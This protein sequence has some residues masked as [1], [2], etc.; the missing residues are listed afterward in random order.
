MRPRVPAG[1][2]GPSGP[3]GRSFTGRALILAVVVITL[4]VSLAVP[5]RAWFA[6]RAE[7][8][9]LRADVE[10]ARE[11]VEALQ[12]Q[13]ERWTDPAFVAAEARRRLHFVL[14]GEVGYVTLG[15]A[16]ASEA[17]AAERATPDPWYTQLWGALEEADDRGARG[18]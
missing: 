6:Q 3:S 13:Q 9:S 16:E 11:R 1:P 4:L 2:T 17:Q 12:I 15:S 7:I 10:S 5:V 14:P 8:A 18:D